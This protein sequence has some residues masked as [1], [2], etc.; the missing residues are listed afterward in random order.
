MLTLK[1]LP[2]ELIMRFARQASIWFLLAVGVSCAGMMDTQHDD[3]SPPE[4]IKE[5]VPPIRNC[6]IKVIIRSNLTYRA[7]DESGARRSLPDQVLSRL[8]TL[9]SP[10]GNTFKI[11]SGEETN[12]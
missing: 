8:A 12:F 6:Q 9:G 2:G 11:A 1:H 10:H 3:E 4:P 5:D 7:E